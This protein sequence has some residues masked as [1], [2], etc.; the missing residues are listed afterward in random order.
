MR[1]L[2]LFVRG[3]STANWWIG[4]VFSWLALACVL[5]CFSVVV[6]R[7]FFNTTTL[8][9]QDLYVWVS[10][11]M[12]TAIAGFALLRDDHVRVDIFYRPASPRW[13]AIADLIGVTIFLIPFV[14]VVFI[15]ALPA[16]QR[17]WRFFEGSPNIGGMPGYFVL[18]S[19]IL[20]FAVVV[21]MQGLAMAARSILVLAGR[22]ELLPE[23]FRYKVEKD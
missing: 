22:E 16:V 11:A 21:G 7:Y 13:K 18:K 4:Q 15:Y 23:R 14:I 19:F 20:V 6:Q 3:V 10:G 1:A 17:S 5:L 12:F 2:A 9:V 8:W